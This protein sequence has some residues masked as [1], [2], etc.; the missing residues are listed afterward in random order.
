MYGKIR[1]EYMKTIEK[2]SVD[3]DI[4]DFTLFIAS[5]LK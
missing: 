3:G 1:Q 5:L 4:T 2:G